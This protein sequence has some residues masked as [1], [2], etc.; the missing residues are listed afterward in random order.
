MTKLPV[1]AFKCSNERYKNGKKAL[2]NGFM[3]AQL[4]NSDRGRYLVYCHQCG[5]FH[6]AEPDESGLYHLK[7][8]DKHDIKFIEMAYVEE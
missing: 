3:A 2:C 1:M 4:L 8:I 7:K 5:I 6:V